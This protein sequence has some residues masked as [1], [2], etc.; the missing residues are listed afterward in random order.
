MRMTQVT[1]NK[2]PCGGFFS[3][4]GPFSNVMNVINIGPPLKLTSF[5]CRQPGLPA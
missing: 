5:S 2:G 4:E 3:L 1:F